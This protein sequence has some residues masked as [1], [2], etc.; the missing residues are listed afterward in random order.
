MTA[1]SGIDAMQHKQAY[2]GPVEYRPEK[3]ETAA[4][5]EAEAI[6]HGIPG[7]V[8]VGEGRDEIGDPAWIVYV[9]YP[10]VAGRLPS[11]IGQ[12]EV[13]VNVTGPIDALDAA[14]AAF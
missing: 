6:L 3:T 1:A 2:L 9:D 11:R 4:R 8:G 14:E 7:V 13:V 12:R 5:A 10:S